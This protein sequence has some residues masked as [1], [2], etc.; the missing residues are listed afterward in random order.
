MKLSGSNTNLPIYFKMKKNN[1]ILYIA[2]GL[3]ALV[4]IYFYT[5]KDEP[6]FEELP[7]NSGEPTKPTNP[8]NPVK[9]TQPAV[10]NVNLVLKV[11]SKGIEVGELQKLLGFTGKDID[12][13]FGQKTENLLFSKKGVKQISLSQY[14]AKSDIPKNPLK[15]G[16]KAM[17]NKKPNVQV[18]TNKTLANGTFSNTGK[19]ED[20]YEYGEF[21]GTVKAV[22]ADK[23]HYVVLDDDLLSPDLVWVKSSDVIK[24]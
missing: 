12:N 1:N 14:K 17:A 24:I 5:K 4:G 7:A 11:G 23:L 9:P 19:V 20:E 6:K 2:L 22:T 18:F 3:A 10:A 16:D 15:I 8:T 21:I 13:D